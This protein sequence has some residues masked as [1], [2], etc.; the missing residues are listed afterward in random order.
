MAT[1]YVANQTTV[2]Y[3]P[4]TTI[5][6]SNG[7]Y[8]GPAETVDVLWREGNWYYIEYSSGSC[9]K[10][11]YIPAS[12]VS[13]ISGTVSLYTPDLVTRYCG[14]A[15]NTYNGP[16]TSLYAVAGSVGNYEQVSALTGSSTYKGYDIK[17]F[18]DTVP[19]NGTPFD[20]NV[21]KLTSGNGWQ[22]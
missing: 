1:G 22:L 20:L 11:M 18:S 15:G 13:N 2:Y 4:S 9:R 21:S 19:L 17:Q 8:A 14:M 7:S 16:G 5:Y 6:P 3:G 10:R 12:A